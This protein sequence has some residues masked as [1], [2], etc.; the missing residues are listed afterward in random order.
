MSNDNM[1]DNELELRPYQLAAI[2]LSRDVGK[3]TIY[4]ARK[5]I[6]RAANLVIDDTLYDRV[7]AAFKTTDPLAIQHIIAAMRYETEGRINRSE[8]GYPFTWQVMQ[9][10]TVLLLS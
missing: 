5:K 10:K 2:E 3:A 6:E 9:D 7:S 8:P 4:Q 1:S